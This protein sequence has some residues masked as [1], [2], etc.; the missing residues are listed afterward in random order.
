VAHQVGD[1]HLAGPFFG[2]SVAGQG[3]DQVVGT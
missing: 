2:L 3:L 1:Q